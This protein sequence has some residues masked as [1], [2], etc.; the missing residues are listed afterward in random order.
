MVR[1]VALAGAQLAAFLGI[2]ALVDLGLGWLGGLVGAEGLSI[3]K[4]LGYIFYPLVLLMGVPT[5]ADV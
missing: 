3:V 4:I 2:V 1:C 5:G